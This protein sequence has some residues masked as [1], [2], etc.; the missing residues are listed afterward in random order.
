MNKTEKMEE[1]YYNISTSFILPMLG[2]SFGWLREYLLN[3]YV[4]DTTKPELSEHIFVHLEYS[5]DEKFIGI[6]QQLR[7]HDDYLDDYDPDAN[8]VMFVFAVPKEYKEDY[9]K[10]IK[11]KYSEFSVSLKQAILGNATSGRNYDIL[12]RNS[13]YKEALEKRLDVSLP[14]NAELLS[15]PNLEKEIFRYKF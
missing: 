6:E 7:D 1:R 3:V 12:T 5:N 10:F 13:T 4:G 2:L 15:V 14:E 9:W 8:T 11:G